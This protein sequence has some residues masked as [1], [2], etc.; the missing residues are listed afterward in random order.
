[1]NKFVAS[2][3]LFLGTALRIAPALAAPGVWNLDLS[4]Y[5]SA[6]GPDGTPAYISGTPEADGRPGQYYF[7]IGAYS[8]IH[9]D[10]ALAINMYTVAASWA[11]KPAE[12]NL[13][14]MYALGQG[15]AVDIPRAMAWMTLAAERKDPKY[16][17]ALALV[18]ANLKPGDSNTANEILKDLEPRY[19]DEYALRRAK[20]RWAEVK[21]SLTGSHTGHPIGPVQIDQGNG[22]H[23]DG[24]L[25]YQ[26]LGASDNPYNTGTVT[27]GAL[28]PATSDDIKASKTSGSNA[29]PK[30]DQPQP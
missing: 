26:A 11:Y 17:K 14:V 30:A 29:Q 20:D 8:F 10:Y 27:V 24:S 28:T 19:G 4:R 13:G 12:Y 5:D 7:N 21:G 23:T 18:E 6:A 9:H 15:T 3:L 25:A 1:M 2:F 22:I 16:L